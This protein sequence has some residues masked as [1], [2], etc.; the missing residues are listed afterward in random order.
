MVARVVQSPTKVRMTPTC[1]SNWRMGVSLVSPG[2]WLGDGST[3]SDVPNSPDLHVIFGY[4]E[5]ADVWEAPVCPAVQL[6]SW[7]AYHPHA[8][9]NY[10]HPNNTVYAA[11]RGGVFRQFDPVLQ[12]T[13]P[14]TGRRS[15]WRLPAWFYPFNPCDPRPPLTYHDD[16]TRRTPGE[17]HVGLRSVGRGQEFVCDT[18]RYPEANAWAERILSVPAA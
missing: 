7:A 4:L 8:I 11:A 14:D 6:P 18:C 13:A 2:S 15:E 1:W 3:T 16:P 9:R 12:L 17:G 10:G 5:V